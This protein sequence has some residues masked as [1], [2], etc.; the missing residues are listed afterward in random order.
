MSGR[1]WLL[2]TIF[3][4]SCVVLAY[5]ILQEKADTDGVAADTMMSMVTVDKSK[6]LSSSTTPIPVNSWE[7]TDVA[8]DIHLDGAGNIIP[9]EALHEL[10]DYIRSAVGQ[11]D[12]VQMRAHLLDAGRQRKLIV[13]QLAQLDGL[14]SK[15]LDYLQAV[16]NIQL[17]TSDVGSMRKVLDARHWMR[18]ELLGFAMAEG[19]F[20]GS[21]AEDRYVLDRME[22][23]ADKALTAEQRA[24]RLAV[25]S[26]AEPAERRAA[27]QPSQDLIDLRSRTEQMRQ[28]GASAEQIQAMRVQFVGTA[29]AERL[30]ALDQA[31]ATWGRRLQAL[32]A[33]RQNILSDLNVAADDKQR[34][35]N[36]LVDR[37]FSGPEALRARAILGIA[38]NPK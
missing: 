32:E 3:A 14:F 12:T 33:A 22:V 31:Q 24:Q 36:L 25:L 26:A 15:Y 6:S 19:F 1:S 16:S 29:A 38:D 18:R 10:F 20:S 35:I 9:D 11:I 37:D 28:A 21:E 2:G 8:G 30:M 17:E 27:L 5:V 23:M 13:A 34:R 7:G 4:A